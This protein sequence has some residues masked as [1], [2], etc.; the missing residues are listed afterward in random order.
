MKSVLRSLCVLLFL[1]IQCVLV[2][3]CGGKTGADASTD[4]IRNYC[5]WIA[6]DGTTIMCPPT[7]GKL[8]ECTA[9]GPNGCG[10]FCGCLDPAMNHYECTL[11][12][13]PAPCP[14]K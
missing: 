7:G 5:T 1:V 9:P 14:L 12:P 3:Q 6:W 2:I 4:A 8:R 10:N 11:Y 13:A